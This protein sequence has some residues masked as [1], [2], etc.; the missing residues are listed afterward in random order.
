MRRLAPVLIVCT[1]MIAAFPGVG[2]SA[3]PAAPPEAACP[4]P[5]DTLHAVV[6]AGIKPVPSLAPSETDAAWHRL[7][8]GHQTLAG[9][10]TS[11]CRPLR[12][13]FYTATDWRRLAT[14]LAGNASA[15]A[16]YYISVPPLSADKTQE[17]SDEAWRIRALGSNFHAL[18]EIN[19]S[20][21]ATWVADNGGTWY[22]AGV[23][24]RRRMAAAG[25]DVSLG[26]TW[27]VN[28]FSS[29]VR[30]GS[31]LLFN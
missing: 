29:A 23:E 22:S 24:A 4:S 3:P 31:T 19:M 25:Y 8:H 12:A 9:T 13:V 18:A 27:A 21:W 26:D 28:E 2:S 10:V 20:A 5:A 16:Q 15:C 14:K 1:L 17:R 30:Q 6:C 11:D 7:A